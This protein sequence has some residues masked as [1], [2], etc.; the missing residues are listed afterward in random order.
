MFDSPEEEDTHDGHHEFNFFIQTKINAI[1]FFQLSL[2][3]KLDGDL[4]II[5]IEHQN[6]PDY[7]SKGI[8]DSLLPYLARTL[9]RCI[10]SS[11][12]YVEGTNEFRTIAATKMWER[13]VTKKLAI[14][15]RDEDIYRTT[16]ATESPLSL[17][18]ATV[19]ARHGKQVGQ[20]MKDVREGINH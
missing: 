17:S 14:Y 3:Q 5:S 18:I 12:T 7:M 6:H 19:T 8:P 4:Q 15:Y 13:L 9:G 20:R 10:C 16:S 11:R 2:R 1:H